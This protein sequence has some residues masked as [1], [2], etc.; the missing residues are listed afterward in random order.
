VVD[1]PRLFRI[2]EAG[3]EY[4]SIRPMRGTGV[5]SP[6]SRNVYGQ[7]TYNNS[8][9]TVVTNN[10]NVSGVYGQTPTKRS[11]RAELEL[12]AHMYH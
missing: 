5:E 10:Y 6:I 12:S 11:I 7:A 1:R 2:G 9:S 3:P 8:S 4:V